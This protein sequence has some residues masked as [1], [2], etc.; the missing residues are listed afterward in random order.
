[1]SS[2]DVT[3]ARTSISVVCLL[4]KVI[5]KKNGEKYETFV[6]LVMSKIP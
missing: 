3:K 1:M 5:Y 4:T 2:R 6:M